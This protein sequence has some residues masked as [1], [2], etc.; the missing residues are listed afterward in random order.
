M[1]PRGGAVAMKTSS[2]GALPRSLLTAFVDGETGITYWSW[3]IYYSLHNVTCSPDTWHYC[4]QYPWQPSLSLRLAA[5]PLCGHH[6]VIMDC[7]PSHQTGT[8]ASIK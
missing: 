1:Y 6:D 3:L 8:T 2:Y 5:L 7:T 4:Y